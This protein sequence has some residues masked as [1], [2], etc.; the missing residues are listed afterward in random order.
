MFDFWSFREL[1]RLRLYSG[2][3]LVTLLLSNGFAEKEKRYGCKRYSTVEHKGNMVC[4]C[5][6]KSFL[7]SLFLKRL[8]A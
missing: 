4:F 2:G 6:S 7:K 1:L 3:I 8:I 5:P